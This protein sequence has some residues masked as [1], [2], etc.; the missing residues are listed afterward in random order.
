MIKFITYAAQMEASPMTVTQA[1]AL[2]MRWNMRADLSTG[3]E[4][5]KLELEWND[6]GHSTGHYTCIICGEPVLHKP[7]ASSRDTHLTRT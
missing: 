3:C 1:T 6:R 2:R 5:L 4:H 7:Q